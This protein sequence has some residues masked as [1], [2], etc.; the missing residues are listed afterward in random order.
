MRSALS[1]VSGVFL[2][3]IREITCC[4]VPRPA[5]ILLAAR[6]KMSWTRRPH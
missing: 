2:H 6:T 3:S 5:G 1:R 4:R